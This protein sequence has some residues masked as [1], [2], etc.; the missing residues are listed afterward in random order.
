MVRQSQKQSQDSVAANL[1][2]HYQFLYDINSKVSLF[3]L[4]ICEGQS[5]IMLRPVV[6]RAV[7]K[8]T[9]SWELPLPHHLPTAAP[10]Y[11]LF[12]PEMV[13][14]ATFEIGKVD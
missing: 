8:P 2:S 13:K 3:I 14:V 6:N 9:L 4:S 10:E 5:Q 11:E 7:T 1:K 12:H